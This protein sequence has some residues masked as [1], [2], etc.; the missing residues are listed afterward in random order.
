[1]SDDQSITA[2]ASPGTSRLSWLLAVLILC[3]SSLLIVGCRT[4]GSAEESIQTTAEPAIDDIVPRDDNW[5]EIERV[6]TPAAVSAIKEFNSSIAPLEDYRLSRAYKIYGVKLK[7][8][9]GQC[10]FTIT[11]STHIYSDLEFV[12]RGYV[13]DRISD[14]PVYVAFYQMGNDRCDRSPIL[15]GELLKSHSLESRSPIFAAS[16]IALEDIDPFEGPIRGYQVISEDSLKLIFDFP[17]H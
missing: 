2:I 12:Y 7:E 6:F 1:M 17:T 10:I 11:L 5:S 15:Q 9:S 13:V 14:V 8:E 16:T 3:V 4:N